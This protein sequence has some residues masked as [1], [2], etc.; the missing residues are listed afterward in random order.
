MKDAAVVVLDEPTASIDIETQT[1][2]LREIIALSR[3]KI[4]I[5]SSHH[6]LEPKMADRIVV[7]KGGAVVEDG[8]Y[9]LLCAKNGE[10][11]RLRGLF[12]K[13]CL[14]SVLE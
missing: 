11:A 12:E 5:F 7:V 9:E 2:L 8:S 10:F 6:S 13:R 3:K 1:Y 14:G 4:C